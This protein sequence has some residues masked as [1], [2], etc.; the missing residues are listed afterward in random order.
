MLE[1]LEN[2]CDVATLGDGTWPIATTVARSGIHE[3]AAYF[4]PF[5]YGDR[6]ESLATYLKP[7]CEWLGAISSLRPSFANLGELD[8]PIPSC[9]GAPAG[10]VA[11]QLKDVLRTAEMKMKHIQVH[12]W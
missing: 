1:T 10:A 4:L 11:E 5:G 2:E 6:A 9:S 8:F 7:R 3:R 12:T